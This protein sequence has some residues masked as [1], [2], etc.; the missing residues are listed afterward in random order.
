MSAPP[1]SSLFGPALQR[2]FGARVPRELLPWIDAVYGGLEHQLRESGARA[3]H[4]HLVCSLAEGLGWPAADAQRAGLVVDAIQPVIDFTDNLAD[5]EEDL[6]NGRGYEHLYDAI[7]A[8]ARPALAALMLAAALDAL[9]EH[10]PPERFATANA[11]SQVL[12]RL[13]RMVH[14]QGFSAADPSHFDGVA[15]A[16]AELLCL[17]FWLQRDPDARFRRRTLA[18]ERWAF[19]FGRY[20]ALRIDAAEHPGEAS[21]AALSDALT[22]CRARW[23]RWGPF[24]PGGPFAVDR[25]LNESP[26]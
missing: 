10:F 2:L 12:H 19:A 1:R 23:P 24:V 13:G 21:R 20:A 16:Q 4:G 8:G 14:G 7:P 22:A 15:G 18:A 5:A 25:F 11:R 6:R 3:T 17:P 9:V 26:G